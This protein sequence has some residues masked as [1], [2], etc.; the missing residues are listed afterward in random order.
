MIERQRRRRLARIE[1][2]HR[3]CIVG[4]ARLSARTRD[5]HDRYSLSARIAIGP[6]ID[7]EQR[8]NFD[9]E[10]DLLTRLTHR[11]LL[12]RLPEINKAARNRPPKRKILALDKND[13]IVD[14]GDY[15]GGDRRALW[16]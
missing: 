10:R 2:T 5:V 13:L 8:A 3:L 14:L 16:A 11:R 9:L 15:V 7:A 12:D 6:R 1:E 4:G